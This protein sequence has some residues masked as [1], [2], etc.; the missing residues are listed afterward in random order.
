MKQG[1]WRAAAP[2]VPS[3]SGPARPRASTAQLVPGLSSALGPKLLTTLLSPPQSLLQQLFPDGRWLG[4]PPGT[5][6]WLLL[7]KRFPGF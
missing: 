3:A 7:P 2:V 1:V 5:S 4:S 6:R